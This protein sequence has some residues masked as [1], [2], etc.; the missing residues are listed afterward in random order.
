MPIDNL[1]SDF[2][3]A[4]DIPVADKLGVPA[5]ERV[6]L[7]ARLI[8]EEFIETIESLFG[9]SRNP[10]IEEAENALATA[11]E[12]AEVNVDLVELADGLCDL[13]YVVAGTRL[14]FGIPGEAVL[15]E[16]HKSNMAKKDGPVREDGKRM[17][18][19]GW[20]GPDIAGVLAKRGWSGK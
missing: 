13:D 14:E 20:V 17:K 3:H 2:H 7:R 15:A 1:V 5:D 16:V 18:P 11:I 10:W 8:C 19:V 12:S 9:K 4:M 6:R